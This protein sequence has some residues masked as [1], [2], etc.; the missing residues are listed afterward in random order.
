M[1]LTDLIK[2]AGFTVPA[3]QRS[4]LEAL[5]RG[6]TIRMPRS[7]KAQAPDQETIL[8]VAKTIHKARQERG[9]GGVAGWEYE[10]RDIHELHIHT[11]R[12]ALAALE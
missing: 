10:P 6:E 5:E 2:A 12:A 9:F 7:T 4:V 11:A 1:K 3:Y 8:K